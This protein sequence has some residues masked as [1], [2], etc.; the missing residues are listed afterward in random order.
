MNKERVKKLI[1]ALRSGAY[2]QCH[3]RLTDGDS[4]C[5]LGVACDVY[6][7]ETGLGEW[8]AFSNEFKAGIGEGLGVP[9]IEVIDW[10]GFK[11]RNPSLGGIPATSLNDV[12]QLN[13]NQIADL[14]E[15]ELNNE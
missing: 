6:H 7:R 1:T 14:L 9:P 3:Y 11:S 10:F 13:F 4:F 15:K 5:C 8:R 2:K 12:D